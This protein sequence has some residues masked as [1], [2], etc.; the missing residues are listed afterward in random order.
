MATAEPLLIASLAYCNTSTSI[1]EPRAVT[2]ESL[3]GHTKTIK[4]EPGPARKRQ[5]LDHLTSDEKLLRRKLKNRVAAQNARDRKKLQMDNLEE[6]VAVLKTMQQLLQ[7]DNERL[8]LQNE[9]LQEQNKE[10]LSKLDLSKDLK[11]ENRELKRRLTELENKIQ[12]KEGNQI[13]MDCQRSFEYASL[14][15]VSQQKKQESLAVLRWMMLLIGLVTLNRTSS[16]ILYKN[17]N[18]NFLKKVCRQL[19]LKRRFHGNQTPNLKWW[20]PQ[21]NTWNPSKN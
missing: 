3:P 8:K 12:S 1:V 19:I 4:I 21:Q 10:L 15:S 5:R 6:E 16:T 7:A 20:G 11:E 14:I 2:L 9:E 17:L 18:K 13:S